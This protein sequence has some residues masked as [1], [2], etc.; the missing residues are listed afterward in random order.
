MSSKTTWYS[1]K[2]KHNCYIKRYISIEGSEGF[3]SSMMECI[4]VVSDVPETHFVEKFV[5]I[6]FTISVSIPLTTDILEVRC[7][8][9]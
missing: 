7:V 1:P 5:L 2:S 3:N 6:L 8:A 4:N 9:L